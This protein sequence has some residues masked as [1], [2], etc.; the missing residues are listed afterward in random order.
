MLY[1]LSTHRCKACVEQIHISTLPVSWQSRSPEAALLRKHYYHLRTCLSV[2]DLAGH[3][4]H[5]NSHSAP[6]YV[7]RQ[8]YE[9]PQNTL[10]HAI[11]YTLQYEACT[12]VH[13]WGAREHL[14]YVMPHVG[15]RK[16]RLM[17]LN[18]R[19]TV[20]GFRLLHSA[21]TFHLGSK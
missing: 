6:A 19:T 12:S 9:S 7:Q 2:Q 5:I 20:G 8:I 21:L 18:S 14:H 10:E 1:C 17:C 13:T 15:Q 4:A 3:K 11:F 16:R